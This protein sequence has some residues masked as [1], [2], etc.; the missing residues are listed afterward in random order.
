MRCRD[1]WVSLY[2]HSNNMQYI[3]KDYFGM[4]HSSQL[5]QKCDYRQRSL[6][7]PDGSRHG[8]REGFFLTTVPEQPLCPRDK[9]CPCLSVPICQ[10]RCKEVPW[11]GWLQY[12]KFTPSQ[13]Q[14]QKSEIEG[15]LLRLLG[16]A[17]FLPRS[18]IAWFADHL[19]FPGLVEAAPNLCFHLYTTF[20]LGAY[21][22][23]N[24]PF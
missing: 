19:R 4:C 3:F 23:P 6:S 11:S 9:E 14:N 21:L 2:W 5:L 18:Y 8:S 22:C 17:C 15:V 1:F 16:R 7:S 24:F 20:S 13:S 10:S 12:Q